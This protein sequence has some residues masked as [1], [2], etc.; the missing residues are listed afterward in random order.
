MPPGLDVT[1]YPVIVA[2]PFDAGAANVTDACASPAVA[3]PIVGAPGATALTV[4]LRVTAG[5]ARY[6][7]LP[8]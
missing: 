1:V 4:K 7:A 6:A 8:A 2:P 5:A 3:V